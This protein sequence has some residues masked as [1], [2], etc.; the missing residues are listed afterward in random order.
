MIEAARQ[1]PPRAIGVLA[2]LACLVLAG[3]SS[4]ALQSAFD[5]SAAPAVRSILDYDGGQHRI[6][7][8]GALVGD[9]ESFHSHRIYS[10]D[11]R[12]KPVQRRLLA[13][14]PV[15]AA[16]SGTT[17]YRAVGPD[18]LADLQKLGRY[19][20]PPGG[21]EG[22]YFFETSE[23]ASNFA[24]MMGDKPYTTTS[25]RVPRAGL[26]K[27][28]RIN[29]AREGPGYFFRTPDMP[30]GPVTIFNRSVLP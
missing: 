25:V 2:I 14:A 22:K 19:R 30:S 17:L 24:R 26:G 7:R 15:L 1:H 13:F 5:P 4:V 27:G 29:P 23:Q 28:D 21:T 11:D 12:L 9:L 3:V 6:D 16:K 18:E 10:Y 20:V 8:P